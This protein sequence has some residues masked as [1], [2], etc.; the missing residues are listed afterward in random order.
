MLGNG[1]VPF[2]SVSVAAL[3][4]LLGRLRI[5]GLICVIGVASGGAVNRLFKA[6]ISRPRPTESL[7]QIAYKVSHESFPSG[8]VVYFIEFF[9]FLLFLS[10]VLLK[11]GMIR[12][13]ALTI[14]GTL[15]GLVGISRV[16]LGAH[17]PSDVLGAYLAGGMW[18][19]LM[20]EVYRR[21]KAKQES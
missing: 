21:L 13:V 20:I 15:I 7:V 2:A 10:F 9:G 19:M 12:R 16:Y 18:L 6:W 14:C 4:L 3:A 5:E 1:W 11:A 8:H 17:W